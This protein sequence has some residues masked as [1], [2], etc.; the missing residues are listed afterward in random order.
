[1]LIVVVDWMALMAH[2]SQFR[3]TIFKQLE[4]KKSLGQRSASDTIVEYSQ[5]KLHF[6]L[7][8][9]G[10]EEF[11]RDNQVMCKLVDKI[12]GIC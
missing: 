1:M 10:N 11:S 6:S 8:I 4:M 9:E 12:V 3:H 2:L 7:N 5:P